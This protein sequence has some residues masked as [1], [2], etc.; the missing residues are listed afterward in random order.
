MDVIPVSELVIN[1]VS[2]SIAANA[3][4]L[5]D[6][7]AGMKKNET[8]T[9]TSKTKISKMGDTVN[10]ETDLGCGIAE[11]VKFEKVSAIHDPRSV[12]LFEKQDKE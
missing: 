7:F 3:D 12:D 6:V 8:L 11:R 1:Q 5:Q 2:T 10:L 4:D 9:I